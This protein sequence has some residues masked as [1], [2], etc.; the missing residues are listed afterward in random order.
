MTKIADF[1]DAD[2]WIVEGALK[3]HYGRMITVKP[4][5]SEIR[6]DPASPEVTVCPTC[7]WEASGVEFAIF[8]I[9]E[10]CYRSRFVYATGEQFG[11]GDDFEDLIACTS[12]TLRLQTDHARTLA[13]AHSAGA[14]LQ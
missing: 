12:T 8:K 2:R 1:T 13:G 4:A 7:Y 3:R 11:P 6:F 5:D 10:D 9:A 14:Q